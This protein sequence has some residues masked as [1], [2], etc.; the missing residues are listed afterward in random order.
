MALLGVLDD[1]RHH[2][3]SHSLMGKRRRVRAAAVARMVVVAVWRRAGEAGP[4]TFYCISFVV[5]SCLS[6]VYVHVWSQVR[7][8][9]ADKAERRLSGASD[10]V[11]VCRILNEGPRLACA[12]KRSALL[13]LLGL[14]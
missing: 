4:D 2:F 6:R 8:L 10:G 9:N 12:G 14:E 13:V 7:S 11:A 1:R 3:G 5:L